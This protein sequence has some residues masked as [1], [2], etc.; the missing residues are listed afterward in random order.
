MIR[1]QS[2]QGAFPVFLGLDLQGTDKEGVK[3]FES[4]I[5]CS[6]DYI[7]STS[8]H[9]ELYKPKLWRSFGLCMENRTKDPN[10]LFVNSENEI[11][12]YKNMSGKS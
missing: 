12:R 11:G 1:L 9:M 3:C 2:N 4:L 8:S 5:M 7:N 10:F 6:T